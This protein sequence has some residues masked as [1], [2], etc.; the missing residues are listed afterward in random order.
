MGIDKTGKFLFSASYGIDKV[1]MSRLSD[2]GRIVDVNYFS[3]GKNPHAFEIDS[4]NRFAYV[5][6]LGSDNIQQYEFDAYK[7]TLIPVD[8]FI[9]ETEKGAGPRLLIFH[10]SKNIMYQGNENDSTITVYRLDLE[11]GDLSSF[12]TVSTLPDGYA[13]K[14]N[15]SELHQTPDGRFLYIANRGH[16]SIAGYE[17]DEG[18]GKLARLG[19]FEVPGRTIRSFSIE[20][21]GRFLY[22]ADQHSGDLVTFSI[23]PVSGELRQMDVMKTGA[24]IGMVIAET[25]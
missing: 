13:E 9:T 2:G 18:S 19:F 16:N 6:C 25:L 17:V 8:P 22:A 14:S 12:Q 24:G 1:S 7:G 4:S 21:S 10:R 3:T 5:P 23:N 11:S 15:L 20:P